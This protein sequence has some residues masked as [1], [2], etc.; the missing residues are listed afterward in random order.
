MPGRSRAARVPSASL[1]G[2]RRA[3]RVEVHLRPPSRCRPR[4]PSRRSMMRAG[5]GSPSRGVRVGEF[6]KTEQPDEDRSIAGLV[7]RGD[8][9]ENAWPEVSQTKTRC[10]LFGWHLLTVTVVVPCVEKPASRS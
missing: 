7:V 2:G 3:S 8:V 5:C 6:S 1:Q 10:V 4:G 9:T